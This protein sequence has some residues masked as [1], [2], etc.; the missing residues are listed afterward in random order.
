MDFKLLKGQAGL[1]RTL[2]GMIAGDTVSHAVLFCG[3]PGIGKRTWGSILARTLLCTGGGGAMP[4]GQCLSCRQFQS[5]NHPRFFYLEPQGRRI[6]I[7]QI[8][9][10]RGRFFLE[11]GNSVCLI[12][13]ADS[14]TAEAAS[15]ILKILEE[16][17]P[18]LYF[19][20]LAAQPGRLL[21]TILSRCQRF[22]LLPLSNQEIRDILKEKFNLSPAREALASHLCGG[23]PGS[24]MALAEDEAL[25]RRYADAA[26]LIRELAPGKSCTPRDLL[27]RAATLTER[28][29]L[30]AL[31]ELVQVILRDGLIWQLSGREDLLLNPGSRLIWEKLSLARCLEDAVELV[32]TTINDLLTT[33]VNRRLTVEGLLL[34]LQRRMS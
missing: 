17:P 13:G 26:E 32:N 6:K 33:N 20:L 2:N 18:A 30:L 4:C 25:E 11:G 16:P 1:K 27:M 23:N 21:S 22:T 31:L 24:A 29:D 19:I 8:R 34:M 3:P 12:A 5:G 9:Q 14:M 10:I 15:S 28:E 7:D